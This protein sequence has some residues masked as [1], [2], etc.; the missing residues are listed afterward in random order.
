[1]GRSLRR[2]GLSTVAF[3]VCA[4]ACTYMTMGGVNRVVVKDTAFGVH[5]FSFAEP[6]PEK[7]VFTT[8]NLE[9]FQTMVADLH[10][11]ASEM[12]VDTQVVAI[13]SRTP[14]GDITNLTREQLVAFKV[15]NV[16]AEEQEGQPL[17]SVSIPGINAPA[18]APPGLLKELQLNLPQL[19]G[20]AV[21]VS[22]AVARRV[23]LAEAQDLD[24]MEKS[25]ANSYGPRVR[26]NGQV[27]TG[28]QVVA[29]KRR[30]VSEWGYRRIVIDD[31]TVNVTCSDNDLSCTVTGAYDSELGVSADGMISKTR[32][33]FEILVVLP[34]A[35]PVVTQEIS[36]LVQ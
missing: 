21:T 4:S 12:G 5:Q 28:A 11:Y 31:A 1:M 23:I 10:D 19:Q 26:F 15:D 29:E 34:L 35:L 20:L 2:H 24:E 7:P 36:A 30:M 13:A 18:L 9:E 33:T 22:T 14:P 6:D 27:W 8:K 17:E 25:L 16:P 3:N 32:F